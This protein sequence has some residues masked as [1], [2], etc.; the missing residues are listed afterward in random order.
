MF[1]DW[2]EFKESMLPGDLTVIGQCPSGLIQAEADRS[3]DG[4]YAVA[5]RFED[6]RFH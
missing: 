3:P 1:D 6:K 2:K 5:G 4:D